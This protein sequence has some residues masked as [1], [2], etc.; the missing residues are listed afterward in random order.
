MSDARRI[1]SAAF[2]NNSSDLFVALGVVLVV[3]MLIVPLPTVLLDALM[4]MNLVLSLLILLIVLYTKRPVEFSIFPTILLVATVFGLALNVSSTRLILSK[5][6]KFDGKMIKAFASFVVGSGGTEGLVIGFVIFIVIIAVQAIVITKGA[7]RVA[8]VAARFALDALPGKQMAIEAEYNS[9]AITEEEAHKKK[10]ELQ[11][12]A[13]FYGAM[14]G[15]SK[16]VSGNVKVGIFITIVNVLGGLI[17]GMTL[18]GEPFLTAL[19]TYTTFTIGDGLLSQF[20]AL[21][22]STATGIIV[23]RSISEGTF[24]A[25]VAKQF[26][27]DARIYWIAAFVLAGFALLPG[28]PW[29][30]LIPLAGFMAFTAY[31]LGQTHLKQ[32]EADK[33]KAAQAKRPPEEGELSPVV[34][35]DPL[36]LELGYGLIPL[37]D[38]DK[39]AE[40]LERVHRIRRESAL[41]LGLVIPRIRIIDNMRLEPSEYC[42]K[43]K[44]V[45]VG[46][47]K[48]RMGYF[49]CINPGGVTEDIGGEKTRDPAFGLP[50]VW[51]SEDKRDQAERA[52]Y[53]VV[54][55]PSIIAT[56]LTEIIK[57]H[58]AEILGRQETQG[59]LETLKKE[60]PAVVEEAQKL[61]SLG[62][63]QKV[64]QA[65]LREQVSIRN[66][67][68]ILEALAD[69]GGITKDTQ[70]LTEKARQALARQICLQYADEER[71]LRVL[72]LEQS[73]EQKIIDSRVE[74]SSGTVAVLEPAVQRAWIKAL[75]RSVA[76][77]QER[78]LI[79]I[80]LCSEAARPLVKSSTERELPDLV[81]LSV[82]EIVPD[83]TV[84]AVGEIRLE[85]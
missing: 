20:P 71:V 21:L 31:R 55:P 75:S 63:I 77:M 70:F 50:A 81:V 10:M 85:E 17:I 1:V 15:A 52:G 6:M 32:A 68:A 7:T 5:G 11:R 65:L 9:G 51:I 41:D 34:P 62:E 33:V 27:Q 84:E 14:D 76:A 8:E 82:P 80:I 45:D 30:V 22:I 2:V 12:E 13:D 23:T 28:F 49:L 56:H 24:G 64:L 60:Y 19:G 47:G 61:L 16:F 54:D 40:L 39:G 43:I 42:F 78:G 59:I 48:I 74:T 69:Y 35:L 29:Y 67:V 37:V 46:R 18:H 73:L 72:T 26:S 79:P 3:V 38:R 36:S 44:G 4:A 25:D 66:M 53:T 83:V 57:R 58:A